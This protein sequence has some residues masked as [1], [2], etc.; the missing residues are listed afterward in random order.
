MTTPRF[1][2]RLLLLEDRPADAELAIAELTAGGFVCTWTRVQTEET[3]RKWGFSTAEIEALKS[4]RAI[5]R[6]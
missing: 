4:E 1:P 2:V 3:L 5:G 6:G